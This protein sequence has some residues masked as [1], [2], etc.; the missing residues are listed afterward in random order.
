MK[1]IKSLSIDKIENNI[2]D[3]S[4]EELLYIAN[5]FNEVQENILI[6]LRITERT[7]TY[8]NIEEPEGEYGDY[9]GIFEGIF[10][11]KFDK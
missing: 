6:E 11:R 1:H 2:K 7:T 4:R 9:G 8:S 5:S 3:F 10:G